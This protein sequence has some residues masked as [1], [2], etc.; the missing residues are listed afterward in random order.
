M[1][2]TCRSPIGTIVHVVYFLFRLFRLFFGSDY[3]DMRRL[4]TGIRFEKCVVR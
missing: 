4:I 2:K 3:T 1:A